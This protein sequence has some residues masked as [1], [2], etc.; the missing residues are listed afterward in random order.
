M[1]SMLFPIFAEI[2]LSSFQP[3]WVLWEELSQVTEETPFT[4]IKKTI[5]LASFQYFSK[6]KILF[7]GNKYF[8]KNKKFPTLII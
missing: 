7:S 2:F 8:I 3:S 4:Y 1:R 5:I 6:D